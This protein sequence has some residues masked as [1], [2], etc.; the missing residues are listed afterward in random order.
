MSTLN[1]IFEIFGPAVG[2]V[3]S[4]RKDAVVTPIALAGEVSNRHQLHRSNSKIGEIVEPLTD[5]GK[6]SGRR[7]R[8]DMQ[9][10]DDSF[11]PPAATPGGILPVEGFGVYDFAGSMHVAR[12]KPGGRV[13]KLL[14]IIGAEIVSSSGPG[15]V[16]DEFKPAPIAVLE[17]QPPGPVRPG[18]AELNSARRWSPHAKAHASVV[19]AFGAERHVMTAL[20][21]TR[22]SFR[23]H[24]VPSAPPWSAPAEDR[25]CPRHAS[26]LHVSQPRERCPSMRSIGH[27]DGT[28]AK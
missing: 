20:H 4:K 9:L 17:R 3:G 28:P 1:Q 25:R 6:S 19:P 24:V 12:L 27:Q 15:R 2:A 11:F 22:P 18:K 10:I 13:G 23:F 7:E 21:S 5:S 14:C 8:S 16:G 26:R